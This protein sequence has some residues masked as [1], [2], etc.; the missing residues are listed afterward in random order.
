MAEGGSTDLGIEG[1]G[2]AVR[3]GSGGFADVYR[4]EQLNLRR[5]VAV[6]V[7]RSTSAENQARLRFERECHALGAVSDHPHIVGVHRSGFT[8]DGRAY[9]I[10]EFCPGGSL[11]DRLRTAGPLSDA[12]VLDVGTKIGKA[13]AVA[14]D[15]GVLH[16][17]VK[18]ANIL[19]TAYGEP[20]LADFGIARVEGAD[21]TATGQI[22]A[23]FTHAAPEV[24]RG[25]APSTRSDVYSLG[26]TLFELRTGSPGHVRSGDESAWILIQRATSEPHPDPANSGIVDP[27]AS[28]IRTATAAQADARHPSVGALVEQLARH[29]SVDPSVGGGAPPT[30]VAGAPGHDGAADRPTAT[31]DQ[32][33]RAPITRPAEPP[34]SPAPYAG[35]GPTALVGTAP[36]G[37]GTGVPGDD[38]GGPAAD[39]G[40]RRR[41][42]LV[43]RVLGLLVVAA[44]V[45]AGIGVAV[46]RTRTNVP[47]VTFTFP[48]ARTGPLDRGETYDLVIGGGDDETRFE[49]L[50]DGRSIEGPAA[51]ITSFSPDGG[52]RHALVVRSTRGDD[53]A[54]TDAVEFY[55]IGDLPPPGYRANLASLTAD[56]ENWPSTLERFDELVDEGHIGLEILPSSRFPALR[57]GFWNLYVPGFGQDRQ[58]GLDYCGEFGLAVPNDCFVTEFIPEP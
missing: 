21:Q 38:R 1:L 53:V 55:V 22:T 46:V 45:G 6:K 50:L 18:P 57:P 41:S 37:G 17:D 56:P 48:D 39:S 43:A 52:G 14:H 32:P 23:S 30:Q 28:V 27:L 29:L 13:L 24:L 10:M 8:D 58:A 5:Q 2:P 12:E 9:L 11:L 42:G 47:E 16:R 19:V 15:A 51:A 33:E 26:S 31:L 20:A 4:A 34:S 35:V 54:V 36:P 40:P 25:E 3:I 7:L 49:L 44:V